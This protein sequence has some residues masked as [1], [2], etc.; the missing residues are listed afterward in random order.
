MKIAR[1]LPVTSLLFAFIISTNLFGKPQHAIATNGTPKYPENFTHFDYVN[2][3]APKGGT[4][5]L[6][7][8]GT[9]NSFNPFMMKGDPAAGIGYIDESY[10]H[11]CL[12]ARAED[13][14][15]TRYGM[16]A[17]SIEIA[18]DRSWVDFV[19]R[20]EARFS[21]NTP[22][23]ASDVVFTFETLMSKGLPFFKMYY[24][25]VKSV[26]ALSPQ[27]VRFH[28]QDTKNK[29]IQNVLGQMPVLS[30]KFYQ[31]YNFQEDTLIPPIGAGP[32]IIKSFIPGREIVF[33]RIPN[34]WGDNLPCMKGRFNPETIKIIYFRDEAVVF[35]AF[36]AGK[37]DLR[38]EST[39]QRWLKGYDFPAVRQGH[40]IKK[41]FKIPTFIGTALL[42]FNNRKPIF[43]DIRVR[44]ALS[45]VL[46]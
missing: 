39:I 21:D 26:E 8:V 28:I 37:Y 36:K 16:I 33:E 1:Y 18:P 3:N 45:L 17:Q 34:W 13:E 24:K 6:A 32:Y 40:V 2:P 30:K 5:V 25:A 4:L 20:P 22:I 31:K 35:E 10:L 46:D 11:G 14:P 23:K 38:M 15:D 44:Q 19:I 7:R 29:E 12:M 9:F 43:E 42:A 27:K 41:A